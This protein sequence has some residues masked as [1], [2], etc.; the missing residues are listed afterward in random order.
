[1]EKEFAEFSITEVF[2]VRNT[3]SILA[4]QV[5]LGSGSVP[6]V[7]AAEGDN[8][9]LGY[10]A[11]PDTLKDKGGCVLIGGKT[12]ALSYQAE[13]F[14]SN[15]SHNLAL[16]PLAGKYSPCDKKVFLFLVGAL[17]KALSWKYTWGNSISSKKIAKDKISLPV[18]PDL[19]P[20]HEYTP[21]DIDWA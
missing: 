2:E 11:C 7:T 20:S 4:S 15:D 21:A 14:C 13:D 10:I 17:R 8:S 1:M 12:M 5:V 19:D 3:K 18:I 6:Y 16:Y 9:V